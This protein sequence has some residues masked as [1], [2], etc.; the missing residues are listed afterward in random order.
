MVKVIRL[1][2]GEI[3]KLNDN[4]LVEKTREGKIIIYEIIDEEG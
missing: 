2:S 1:K 4:L 3:K